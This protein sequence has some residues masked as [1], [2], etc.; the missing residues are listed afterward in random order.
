M[1]GTKCEGEGR[2]A[3]PSAMRLDDAG[4]AIRQLAR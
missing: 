2:E 1:N 3:R 4:E